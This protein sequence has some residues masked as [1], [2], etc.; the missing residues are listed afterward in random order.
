MKKKKMMAKENSNKLKAKIKMFLLALSKRRKNN[1]QKKKL[2][3]KE[4]K[5][6]KKYPVN[7]KKR[8]QKTMMK[9]K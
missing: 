2:K 9:K 1:V 4:M 7:L 8:I 6:L 5:G 3:K